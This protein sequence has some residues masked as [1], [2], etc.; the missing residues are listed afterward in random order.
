MPINIFIINVFTF[1]CY[2]IS[3]SAELWTCSLQWSNLRGLIAKLRTPLSLC[4]LMTKKKLNTVE[5]NCVTLVVFD[6]M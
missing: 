1:C 2:F 4:N 6:S 3:V 5:Y